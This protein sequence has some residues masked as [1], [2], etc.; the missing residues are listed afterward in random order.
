M[1]EVWFKKNPF[2]VLAVS[3]GDVFILSNDAI[4]SYLSKNGTLSSAPPTVDLETKQ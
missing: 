3:S 4:L 1:Q 2:T